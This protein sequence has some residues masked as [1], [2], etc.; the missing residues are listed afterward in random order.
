[1]S[2][3]PEINP[4]CEFDPAQLSS[5]GE[6]LAVAF[7][8]LLQQT[9]ESRLAQKQQRRDRIEEWLMAVGV[10][11]ARALGLMSPVP[12]QSRE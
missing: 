4:L 7:D 1:M 2:P 6:A 9:Y 5:D 11:T 12:R 10:A 8:G 3:I